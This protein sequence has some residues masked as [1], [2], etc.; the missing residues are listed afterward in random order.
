[1][2]PTH[3]ELIDSFPRTPSGKVDRRALPLP[4]LGSGR[5]VAQPT[6]ATEEAVV[7][8]WKELLGR[9]FVD[10]DD[11]FFDVGGHSLIA[12]RLFSR[13]HRRFDTDLP[14]ASLFD[15]STPRAIARL[16]DERAEAAPSSIASDLVEGAEQ[17]FVHVVEITPGDPSKVPLFCVHGAGGN[18]VNFRDLAAELGPDLPF[19][20]LQARGVGGVRSP[21]ANLD[22]LCESYL[23]EIRTVCADGPL[24]L[25]GFSGGGLI[26]HELGC[27]L[28][29]A[30]VPVELL[31]L[32]DTFHPSV[33]VRRLSISE[34]WSNMVSEGPSC[35]WDRI[36]TRWRDLRLER[37][38]QAEWRR[39]KER[40]DRVPIEMRDWVVTNNTIRLLSGY[41]PRP[42]PGRVVLFSAVDVHP[43]YQHAGVARRVGCHWVET[44][45]WC[46]PPAT[47]SISSSPRTSR[48]SPLGCARSSMPCDESPERHDTRVSA[49]TCAAGRGTAA[50]TAHPARR[51]GARHRLCRNGT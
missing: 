13:I 30:G 5:P 22:E 50:R 34:H 11:D 27:R 7:D 15:A 18:V 4:G 36:L 40:G 10:P 46:R 42:Y 21:H 2:V 26:A 8:L 25:A 45:M 44:S 37:S 1:M 47:T 28:V 48:C 3:V 23:A 14:L 51:A 33:P 9:D 43:I 29:D 41:V 24:V 12:V 35:T 6:T 32:L 20:G 49:P 16:I 39:L 31:V 19:F 38:R 17:N